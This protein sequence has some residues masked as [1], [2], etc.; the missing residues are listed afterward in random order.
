VFGT[1]SEVFLKEREGETRN[2][3]SE[4]EGGS[5][6]L[7]DLQVLR[8]QGVLRLRPQGQVAHHPLCKSAACAQAAAPRARR[9]RGFRHEADAGG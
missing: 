7:A 3:E 1:G 5:V 6:G 9:T 4:G 8:G 2:A